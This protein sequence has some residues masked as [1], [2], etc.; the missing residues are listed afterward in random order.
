MSLHRYT[1]ALVGVATLGMGAPASYAADLCA[2]FFW[3]GS[4]QGP[5]ARYKPRYL[6]G[7][8]LEDVHMDDIVGT[9]IRTKWSTQA[10]T[11]IASTNSYG[12]FFHP[13]FNQTSCVPGDLCFPGGVRPRRISERFTD[14]LSVA[15]QLAT[16]NADPTYQGNLNT[17][18]A[19]SYQIIDSMGNGLE[20]SVSLYTSLIESYPP[21][22][23]KVSIV[24]NTAIPPS[25]RIAVLDAMCS[26]ENVAR[27]EELD[28]KVSRTG[29]F[30]ELANL[31]GAITNCELYGNGAT[32]NQMITSLTGLRNGLIV[33]RD[34]LI[35][36]RD[37]ILP[38]WSQIQ[39]LHPPPTVLPPSCNIRYAF[40]TAQTPLSDFDGGHYGA[41][42]S[43]LYG[44]WGWPTFGLSVDVVKALPYVRD[45]ANLTRTCIGDPRYGRL[46]LRRHKIGDGGG[47]M[48]DE[49]DHEYFV[50]V[51][52]R[53]VD[54]RNELGDIETNFVGL[55]HTN[56]PLIADAD[57]DELK[58][59]LN[60]TI[61]HVLDLAAD[62][63][64]GVGWIVAQMQDLHD[65]ISHFVLSQTLTRNLIGVYLQQFPE[66]RNEIIN[67]MITNTDAVVDQY[68]QFFGDEQRADL[69]ALLVEA[70]AAGDDPSIDNM[71]QTLNEIADELQAEF[72]PE[73]FL[74]ANEQLV[75]M[76]A[77]LKFIFGGCRNTQTPH[78]LVQHFSDLPVAA[79]IV[80]Q[81]DDPAQCGN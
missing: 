26:P 5:V 1:I 17:A 31:F 3:T 32:L 71:I 55:V 29:E 74:K 44:N 10:A 80:Q 16:P 50:R 68:G 73:D 28:D 21:A 12:Y 66:L 23:D 56:A 69:D 70:A 59:I 30:G 48:R 4:R 43:H 18:R 67:M 79:Q 75:T 2:T 27:L 47:G 60:Q 61:L 24:V 78:P 77:E 33:E 20:S 42:L 65:A 54:L 22:I 57:I 15:Q 41:D 35:A 64:I 53:L 8:G 34:R 11:C 37:Q 14:V 36:D 58:S 63:S 62:R 76:A 52:G 39:G 46:D 51:F 38:L 6:I 7:L 25:V 40:G 72:V 9:R 45:I 13:D 49:T 81:P 19:A